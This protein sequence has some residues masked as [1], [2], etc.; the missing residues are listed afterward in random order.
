MGENKETQIPKQNCSNEPKIQRRRKGYV[1]LSLDIRNTLKAEISRTGV[2]AVKL[3]QVADGA[4]ADLTYL[5][6]QAWVDGAAK[7]AREENLEFALSAW[8]SLPDTDW[9]SITDEIRAELKAEGTRTGKS[10]SAL[11]RGLRPS[12]IGGL[13]ASIVKN[14]I[15][16][17]TKTAKRKHLD[18]VLARWRALPSTT[19][20][21]KSGS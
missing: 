5:T 11:F 3:L 16:G 17:G 8:R 21:G 7:Q 1:P 9:V 20:S 10:P 15:A 12:E 6:V 14:W 2:G 13:N 19:T 18:F 4:P